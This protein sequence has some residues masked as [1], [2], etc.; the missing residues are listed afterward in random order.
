MPTVQEVLLPQ[1]KRV[2]I[3]SAPATLKL[4]PLHTSIIIKRQVVLSTGSKTDTQSSTTIHLQIPTSTTMVDLINQAVAVRRL[5]F[6][7]ML[8]EWPIH[9]TSSKRLTTPLSSSQFNQQIR[10]AAPMPMK[11]ARPVQA[12]Q[13]VQAVYLPRSLKPTRLLRH[14]R[15]LHKQRQL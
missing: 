13:P 1:Q 8:T 12:I 3:T 4:L 2:T 6:L 9:R 5:P 14:N 7:T 10:R 11:S 15:A